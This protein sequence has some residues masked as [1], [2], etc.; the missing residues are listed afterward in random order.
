MKIAIP[1]SSGNVCTVLDF[2]KWLLVVEFKDS[3]ELSRERIFLKK[4]SLINIAEEIKMLDIQVIICGAVSNSLA[5]IISGYGIKIIS[6]IKGKIEEVLKAYISGNLN[7]P[8]F[9][10][11]GHSVKEIPIKNNSINSD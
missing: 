7:N 8:E 11:P 10:L 4:R 5:K 2:S 3:D 6:Q 9:L 1:E